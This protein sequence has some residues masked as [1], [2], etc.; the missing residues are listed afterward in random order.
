M[1]DLSIVVDNAIIGGAR[2]LN[3]PDKYRIAVFSE[4]EN[5]REIS[6]E[7]STYCGLK[8]MFLFAELDV[9]HITEKERSIKVRSFELKSGRKEEVSIEL[10]TQLSKQAVI[11]TFFALE[12]LPIT[13]K[14][15]CIYLT[16][17]LY[18]KPV[19]IEVRY[20]DGYSENEI[21]NMLLSMVYETLYRKSK[22]F[23]Y[24]N[25]FL[26]ITMDLI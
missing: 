20:L 16:N 8:R 6:G 1:G 12:G 2:V 13:L 25:I 23:S 24:I 15:S 5:I 26:E 7:V 17:K 22:K 19:E 3:K 11:L 14:N 18:K 4:D 9:L 21:K 10:F